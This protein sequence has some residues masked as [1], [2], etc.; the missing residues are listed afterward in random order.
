MIGSGALGEGLEF[1]QS[2][3]PRLVGGH[4]LTQHAGRLLAGQATEVDGRF[5]VPGAL[6]DTTGPVAQGEDVTRAD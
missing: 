3:H 4:D 6:K 5:G 1:G 2:R